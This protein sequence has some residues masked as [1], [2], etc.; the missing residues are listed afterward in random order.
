M[1]MMFGG[2]G[3][4]GG[5]GGGGGRVKE[6]FSFSLVLFPSFHCL[7]PWLYLRMAV[8]MRE[9]GCREPSPGLTLSHGNTRDQ[10]ITAPNAEHPFAL[11]FTAN[12][13]ETGS[14]NA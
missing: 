13:A 5:G 7:C 11:V 10:L 8:F 9:V 12:I 2:K 14:V 6:L 4:E 1:M 3:M